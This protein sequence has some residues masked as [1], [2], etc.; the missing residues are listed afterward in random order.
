MVIKIMMFLLATTISGSGLSHTVAIETL[1]SDGSPVPVKSDNSTS[2][3]HG[4]RRGRRELYH[5]DVTE[6]GQPCVPSPL[7]E[8]KVDPANYELGC[9]EIEV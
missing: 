2:G 1:A 6:A 7:L 5:V 4:S 8:R 3:R 9:T